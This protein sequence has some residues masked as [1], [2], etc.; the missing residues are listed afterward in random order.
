MVKARFILLL[1]FAVVCICLV[2]LGWLSND[3][4]REI[5]LK[6]SVNGLW[7][8]NNWSKSQAVDYAYN[9]ESVGSWI[10]INIKG[11]TIKEMQKTC[12]HESAHELFA[13]YCE[14]NIT[15]CLSDIGIK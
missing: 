14:N 6:K 12:E 2:T 4:Y 15:K 8:G 11:M 3:I 7:I 10:C 5:T 9:R 1:W 13:R